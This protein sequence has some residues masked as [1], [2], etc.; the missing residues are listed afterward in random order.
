MTRRIPRFFAVLLV[1]GL[2]AATA[3]A[4]IS[5]SDQAK[6]AS[7]PV[8]IESVNRFMTFEKGF[9]ALKA[10]EPALAEARGM[11]MEKRVR[12]MSA[13]PA[14]VKLAGGSAANVADVVWTGAALHM[15]MLKMDPKRARAF[16]GALTSGQAM[17][18]SPQQMIFAEAHRADLV[19]WRQELADIGNAQIAK[20]GR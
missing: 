14:A 10:S 18:P 15:L 4:Q 19:R 13:I 5:K 3:P 1:S 12:V 11:D 2:S 20:Y 6:I 17:E 7:W 8:S 9:G 16:D